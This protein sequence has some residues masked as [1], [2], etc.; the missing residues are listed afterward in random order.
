[1]LRKN[2]QDWKWPENLTFHSQ[3][4]VRNDEVLV[5]ARLR[6]MRAGNRTWLGGRDSAPN[7]VGCASLRL[8]PAAALKAV[9]RGI[10]GTLSYLECGARD[11][12]QALRD[13]P[14][15]AGFEFERLENQQVEPTPTLRQLDTIVGHRDVRRSQCGGRWPRYETA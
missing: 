1:M 14:A 2:R 15:V 8:D 11:L 13:G 7:V 12:A 6:E 10:E 9:Q 3:G 4:P 5:N